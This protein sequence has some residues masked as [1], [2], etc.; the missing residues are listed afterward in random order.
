M[1]FTECRVVDAG[2]GLVCHATGTFKYLHGLPT[3]P[4]GRRI[5]RLDASD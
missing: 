3:G 1:A 4:D 5:R 2:G